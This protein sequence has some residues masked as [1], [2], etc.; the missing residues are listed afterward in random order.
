MLEIKNLDV[1]IKEEDKEILKDFSLTI[2]EGEI[3]VI[4]PGGN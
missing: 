3:H 1:K 2:P 4:M